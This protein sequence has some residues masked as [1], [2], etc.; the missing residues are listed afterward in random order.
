MRIEIST[1]NELSELDKSILRLLI[2]D[3]PVTPATVI[4]TT[5]EPAPKRASAKRAPAKPKAEDTTPDEPGDDEPTPGDDVADEPTPDTDLTQEAM[6]RASD[7]ISEGRAAD[8]KAALAVVGVKKVS[9]LVT[10]EQLTQFL[11]EIR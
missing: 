1:V 3:A 4:T 11:N 7:L 9:E 5:A 2:G 8:V 6:D 10:T